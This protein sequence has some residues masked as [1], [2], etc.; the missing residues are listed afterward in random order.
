M[1][2]FYST[3]TKPEYE[4][5]AVL[6]HKGLQ[7][8][9]EGVQ[10][11]ETKVSRFFVFYQPQITTLGGSPAKVGGEAKKVSDHLHFSVL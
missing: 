9:P 4:N 10:K 11:R 5:R 1:R 8:Q 7:K 6:A 3:T 2:H